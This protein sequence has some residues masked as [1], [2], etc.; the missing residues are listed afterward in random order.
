MLTVSR[1]TIQLLD[2]AENYGNRPGIR[3]HVVLVEKP[4]EVIFAELNERGVE[5]P[6]TVVEL[7]SA[8]FA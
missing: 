6:F 4:Y 2:R 5:K 7:P 1:L 8:A 3:D